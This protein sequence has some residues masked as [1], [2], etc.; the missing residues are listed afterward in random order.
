MRRLV[1]LAPGRNTLVR[2]ILGVLF[3]AGLAITTMQAQIP[4]RNVNMV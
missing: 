3:A 1:P 2:L 4:G